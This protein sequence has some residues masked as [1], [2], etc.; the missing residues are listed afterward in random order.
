MNVADVTRAGLIAQLLAPIPAGTGARLI[1][2]MNLDHV[3]KLR[4]NAA[5][6]AAYRSAWRVTI[7]GAPV[8]AYARMVGARVPERITG[9]DLFEE[10]VQLWTPERHRL[11]FIVSSISAASRIEALLRRNGFDESS[12]QFEVPP[13]GFDRDPELSDALAKRVSSFRPSHLVL[14]LGAPKSEIWTECHRD[15]LGDVNVLCVGAAVEFVAGLKRRSPM[16]MRRA[17][18]EWFWRFA[19]EPRRL[20]RRYFID[21]FAFVLAIAADVK[22]GGARPAL[23]KRWQRR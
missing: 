15:R 20:F 21:S 11:F 7:D 17:G 12:A 23:V 14:A 3:V 9:A 10:I 19:T 4:T 13:F 22:S 1:A 18:L 8:F 5:F 2:T 6:R 16:W